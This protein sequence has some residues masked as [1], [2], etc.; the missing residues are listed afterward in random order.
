MKQARCEFTM[1]SL[2]LQ[3]IAG[4]PGKQ[5]ELRNFDHLKLLFSGNP[6]NRPQK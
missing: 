3:R 4:L 1:K 5:R 6:L 2:K